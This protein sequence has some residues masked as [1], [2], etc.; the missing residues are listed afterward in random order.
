MLTNHKLSVANPSDS[1]ITALITAITTQGIACDRAQ[2]KYFLDAFGIHLPNT[3]IITITGTN[4]KGTTV[5]LLKHLFTYNQ[6]SFI[7]HTSPHILRFN[8]RISDGMECISNSDLY[9][10]LQWIDRHRGE[11]CIGYHQL[12]FLVSC[13]LAKQ[14]QPQWLILEVGIGGRLDPAN[15][16]DADIAVITNIGLD[17][18]ELLGDTVEKIGYEKVHIARRGRPIFVGSKMPKTVIDYCQEIGAELIQSDRLDHDLGDSP[19]ARDSY[20]CVKA[21][22]EYL[23][24]KQWI[25]SPECGLSQVVVQGRCQILQRN[26][27]IIVDV[28]HNYDSARYLFEWLKRASFTQGKCCIGLFSALKGKDISA[29]TACAETVLDQLHVFSLQACDARAYSLAEL[30]S[31]EATTKLEM[32]FHENLSQAL[33]SLYRVLGKDDILVVFGSFVT[34]GQFLSHYGNHT[35]DS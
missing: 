10:I 35:Q 34:V 33:T 30:R 29:M 26:P 28:A 20:H 6:Q 21:I 5:A 22:A 13:L 19:L 14:K 24:K 1:E 3:R 16:F 27:Y 15:L 2:L 7:A 25:K 11:Y 31:L 12:S 18:T 4:G 32:L 23:Y 17:H 9:A 8:E